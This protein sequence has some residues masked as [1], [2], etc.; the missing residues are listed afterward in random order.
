M[1]DSSLA[2]YDIHN[3]AY[4]VE[5]QNIDSMPT[6][7]IKLD[8]MYFLAVSLHKWLVDPEYDKNNRGY[9]IATYKIAEES[10]KYNIEQ[11]KIALDNLKL[12]CNKEFIMEI[13]KG[14]IPQEVKVFK[15]S[16]NCWRN[17]E[18]KGKKWTYIGDKPDKSHEQLIQR[19]LND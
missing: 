9:Y 1:F 8:D 16:V 17:V 7:K 3:V 6:C 14:K 18:K 12:L 15:F 2:K 19:L 10:D 4:N 11:T 13:Q 5:S